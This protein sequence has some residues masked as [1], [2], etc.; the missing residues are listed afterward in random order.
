MASQDEVHS[1]PR[2]AK[3][4]EVNKQDGQSDIGTTDVEAREL[5]P[6]PFSEFDPF[7]ADRYRSLNR[8]TQT[9][10]GEL[11]AEAVGI[12]GLDENQLRSLQADA[13]E[14]ERWQPARQ[15]AFRGILRLGA[16]VP[17]RDKRLL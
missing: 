9:F 6:A 14:R 1:K 5:P 2:D 4:N 16:A 3:D 7:R 10:L 17:S 11:G 8:E 13:E 12:E 15:D